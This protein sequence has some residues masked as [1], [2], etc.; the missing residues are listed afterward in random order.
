MNN[1]NTC[2]EKLEKIDGGYRIAGVDVFGTVVLEEV[3]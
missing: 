1:N 2:F 3:E